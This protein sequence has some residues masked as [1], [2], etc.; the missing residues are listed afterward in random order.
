MSKWVRN[1]FSNMLLFDEPLIHEG[2]V[3]NSVENFYQA[4]KV[5][6]RTLREAISSKSPHESKSCFRNEPYK[7]SI[8]DSWNMTEKLR[9]MEFALRHKFKEGTSWYAKLIETGDEDIVEF[10]NWG[11]TFWG[12]DSDTGIGQ[13]RLGKLLMKI[14]GEYIKSKLEKFYE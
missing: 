7:S 14:R 3:Y 1:W 4:M 11:D 8:R 6:D 13:N 5:S 2:I 10:N 9:V 12:V